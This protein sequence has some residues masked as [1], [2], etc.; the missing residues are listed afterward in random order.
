MN[1]LFKFTNEM[2][3]DIND[4]SNFTNLQ[5]NN[6]KSPAQKK[7]LKIEQIYR[8]FC[9]AILPSSELY[10][11][12]EQKNIID[13]EL[14]KKLIKAAKN[15]N[16]GI[17][18]TLLKNSVNINYV[19]KN[20]YTALMLASKNNHFEIVKILLSYRAKVNYKN[21]FDN[22]ALMM[23]S[24]QKNYEIMKL[25]I[26]KGANVEYLTNSNYE[27][28][29]LNSN[30]NDVVID[31]IKILL[32]KDY[33]NNLKKMF[34]DLKL[35]INLKINYSGN[36]QDS[37]LQKL[38]CNKIEKISKINVFKYDDLENNFKKFGFFL[39]RLK[40]SKIQ[41]NVMSFA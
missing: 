17:V 4:T 36:N 7:E 40:I 20:S 14:E 18:L 26:K 9:Q 35:P 2:V 34:F 27:S 41:K 38:C 37:N 5:N 32:Y 13:D 29:V 25:L 10:Y 33:K 30:N 21:K 28:W 3:S 16:I 11:N 1:D 24:Q 23:A 8:Q 15:G 22:T 31:I 6:W 19:D 12:I 39:D